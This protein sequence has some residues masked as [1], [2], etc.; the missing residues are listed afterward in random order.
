[1]KELLQIKKN[2]RAQYFQE[3]TARSDTIKNP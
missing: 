2:E 1:M 3:A